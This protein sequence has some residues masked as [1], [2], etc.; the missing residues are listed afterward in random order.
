MRAFFSGLIG[1][2]IGGAIVFLLMS[3]LVP[4]VKPA[5]EI[6][7]V[8]TNGETTVETAPGQ[9][10][11]QQIYARYS[12]A[13]VHVKAAATARYND[14]FGFQTPENESSSG[15]GFIVS[16]DGYIVTN[17]HV[18]QGADNIKVQLSDKA[19][20]PAKLVG[21]DQSTDLAFLKAD[22][23]G[24]RH[25]VLPLGDSRS[26]KVGQ[27]VYAIGN[28]LGFDRSLSEGIVSALNRDI[29]APNNFNIPGAIQTDA[30]INRGNS[31]G[32]LISAQGKV[33][34]VTAQIATE[35]SGNIGIAFD[36]PSA[37][38]K[39]VFAD[40]KKSGK[41]SHPWI[42]IKGD[43]LTADLAEALRLSVKEGALIVEILSGGPAEKAGLK[44]ADRTVRV[45]E[46]VYDVGGDVIIKFGKTK[47]RS[48]DDLVSVV[49]KRRSGERVEVTVVGSDN[50][51]R[52]VEV[53]LEE[54]PDQL[55]RGR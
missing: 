6:I 2:V 23:S 8:P 44:G 52:Q 1:A 38:V 26:V 33:I 11:P 54:R 5:R 22:L 4:A 18:V 3:N 45:G 39:E 37:T 55:P 47:I 53:T 40:I 48:M 41:A 21:A 9:L 32:P 43:T 29:T 31:G 34:G 12:G 51:T 15:S 42:G 36:I 17:A 30:A 35:G 24:H 7:R 50:K 13:V 19:E 10:T 49:S 27:P 46:S 28:P 16:R 14:F 25:T 20:V